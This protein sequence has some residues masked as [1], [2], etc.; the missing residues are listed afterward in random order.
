MARLKVTSNV[1][2]WAEAMRGKHKDVADAAV[3]ALNEAAEDSVIE[4]RRDIA[5]AGRFGSKWQ[6]GLKFL[7]KDEG[8]QSKVR[9]FH[10]IGLSGVFEH[11]VNISGKPLLWI[12][13]TRGAPRPSRSGKKLTLAN[14]HGTPLLFDVADHDPHRK[15]LYIGVKQARIPKLWHIT[16]IVEKHMKQL[17]LLFIKYFKG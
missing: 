17:G 14:V 11:G 13:T 15:P 2:K 1:D 8:L 5:G 7:M 9:I 4:G 10:K 16:D 12:P 3:A 6:Q